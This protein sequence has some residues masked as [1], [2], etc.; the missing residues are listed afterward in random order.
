MGLQSVFRQSEIHR[1]KYRL[2]KKI[3]FTASSF[4]D[5]KREMSVI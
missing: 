3:S 5:G 1:W 2:K 4:C